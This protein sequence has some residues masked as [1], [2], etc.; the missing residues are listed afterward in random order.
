MLT[1]KKN[2]G[3]EYLWNKIKNLTGTATAGC[4]LVQSILAPMESNHQQAAGPVAL[5]YFDASCYDSLVLS[6]NAHDSDRHARKR[7]RWYPSN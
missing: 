1:S 5:Q 6:L 2:R 3:E 4:H 7:E